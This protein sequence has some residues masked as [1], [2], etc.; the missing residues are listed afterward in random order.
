MTAFDDYDVMETERH[1]RDLDVLIGRAQE[2]ADRED[3]PRV[4]DLAGRALAIDPDNGAARSLLALAESHASSEPGSAPEIRCAW[5]NAVVAP[6]QR[7]CPRCHRERSGYQEH[8][9]ATKRSGPPIL[10][11]IGGV[12]LGALGV[13]AFS[14]VALTAFLFLTPQERS[15]FQATHPVP[16]GDE[17]VGAGPVAIE[18]T[19]CP[20]QG[21][22]VCFL[23]LGAP[24]PDDIREIAAHFEV[25]YD[26]PVSV[27]PSIDLVGQERSSGEL[28]DHQR[29]QLRGEAAVELLKVTYPDIWADSQITLIAVTE[30]DLFDSR[31][32]DLNYA[33]SVRDLRPGRFVV[34]SNARMDDAAWG[35]ETNQ[36]VVARRTLKLI[37]R[38]IGAL[39]YGLHFRNDPASV[40]NS[41]FGS[42]AG[43]DRASLH[44]PFE[45]L[46]TSN[47]DL[48]NGIRTWGGTGRGQT[49]TFEL[50]PGPWEYCA[51][52]I[53]GVVD[54]HSGLRASL[55]DESGVWLAS[56]SGAG[57]EG[58]LTCTPIVGPGRFQ[59]KIFA[60][61]ATLDWT[62]T[63][64]PRGSIPPP[65]IELPAWDTDSA[66]RIVPIS[67]TGDSIEFDEI[68]GGFTPRFKP[69]GDSWTF[70]W[71]AYAAPD[72]SQ[73][74]DDVNY[75]SMELKIE[76]E[77]GTLDQ[78]EQSTIEPG[79]RDCVD[80]PSSQPNARHWFLI[81]EAAE[82]VGV[83]YSLQ[84]VELAD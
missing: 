49:A 5:C 24:P 16:L 55:Y 23:G 64:G 13:V 4:R 25:T 73:E 6:D 84:G 46:E 81:L 59:V 35:G 62:V 11:L 45:E 74:P 58:Q 31:N 70:C 69:I 47:P 29:Q 38:E 34:V 42:R 28:I 50:E 18:A 63:V 26:F 66:V 41:V 20:G 39:H 60:S 43:V 71:E 12:V 54:H 1:T 22:R 32:P 76:D 83:K 10:V 3:W 61:P 57:R 21:Q 19:A 75:L 82:Q 33:Y 68:A 48:V 2:A 37:A 77:I 72:P 51:R 78:W 15:G 44:I 30:H 9:L 17:W 65:E 14:A 27:L 52:I 79:L 56:A 53:G 80:V 67:V 7:Y 36:S 8:R 40:M